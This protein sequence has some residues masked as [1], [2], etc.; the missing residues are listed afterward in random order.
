MTRLFKGNCRS[1]LQDILSHLS[2]CCCCCVL[3]RLVHCLLAF[4]LQYNYV[5]SFFP[6]NPSFFFFFFVFFL[7]LLVNCIFCFPFK[8]CP[9]GQYSSE[10]K[11]AKISFDFVEENNTESEDARGIFLKNFNQGIEDERDP[12]FEQVLFE[13]PLQNL[14][15]VHGAF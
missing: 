2:C 12:G 14:R 1:S 9:I 7:I 8:E 11:Y 4:S 10:R 13:S 5:F 6:W 3:V 15:W